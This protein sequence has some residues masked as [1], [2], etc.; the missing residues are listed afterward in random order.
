MEKVIDKRKL[1]DPRTIMY[2]AR[3]MKFLQ[4][5]KISFKPTMET[6]VLEELMRNSSN[7]EEED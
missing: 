7:K 1:V 2:R 3:I 5:R 6:K 4:E